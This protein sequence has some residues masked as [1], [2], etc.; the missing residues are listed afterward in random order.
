MRMLEL[1]ALPGKV[2]EKFN[3]TEKFSDIDARFRAEDA[4]WS[5]FEKAA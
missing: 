3:R 1:Q 4:Q 2:S 5:L